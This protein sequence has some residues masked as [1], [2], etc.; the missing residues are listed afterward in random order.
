MPFTRPSLQQIIERI[1]ADMTLKLGSNASILRRAWTRVWATVYAGAVH[2]LYGFID[3]VKDQFFIDT[4]DDEQV[5]K[6]ADF[7]GLTRGAAE[8]STG[9]I[10]VQGTTG[11]FLPAG[12]AWFDAAGTRYVSISDATKLSSDPLEVSVRCAVTGIKGNLIAGTQLQLESPVAGVDNIA[13]VNADQ[14]IE[15]GADLETM[16]ALK[17]RLLARVQHPPQGGSRSDYEAWAREESGLGIVKVYGPGDISDVPFLPPNGWVYIYFSEAGSFTTP[18]GG[19]IAA[20][21]AKIEAKMP[22]T[23]RIQV[24][25]LEYVPLTFVIQAKQAKGYTFEQM[26]A[27]IEAELVDLA[28]DSGTPYATLTLSQLNEAISR[29]SSE[30]THILT[31]PSADVVLGYNQIARV[32]TPITITPL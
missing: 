22:V 21:K 14:P 10:D 3:W 18:T 2:M 32:V 24:F 9:I 26:T 19:K 13:V 31:T 8:Y 5:I 28:L 25:G 16:D 4:A 7:Y 20:V 30:S 11:F 12:T 27:D 23:A 15:L 1:L 17:A 6:K 29:P